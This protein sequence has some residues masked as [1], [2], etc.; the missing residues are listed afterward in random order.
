M[1][2]TLSAMTCAIGM[3][4]VFLYHEAGISEPAGCSRL[5]SEGQGRARTRWMHCYEA[6]C[7]IRTMRSC[8]GLHIGRK[9]VC[10]VAKG[11]GG[12]RAAS[13]SGR[14]CGGGEAILI[15][16]AELGEEV[17]EES[18]GRE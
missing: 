18:D 3:G 15:H 16:G 7:C 4:E 17:M 8:A 14:E 9:I 13:G 2:K 5:A 6:P 11:S 10:I 12:R 1:F